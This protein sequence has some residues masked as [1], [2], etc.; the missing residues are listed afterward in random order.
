[1]VYEVWSTI[2]KP[3]DGELE[4]KTNFRLC[5]AIQQSAALK[6]LPL[7]VDAETTLLE[8]SGDVI[9]RLDLRFTSGVAL[10]EYFSFE[11]KRLYAKKGKR[12]YSLVSDYLD[13]GMTRYVKSQYAP[14]RAQGGMIAYVHTGGVDR[15]IA[16]F[17]K[18]L[19]RCFRKL[20]MCPPGEASCSRIRPANTMILETSHQRP[21]SGST[22]L[23][24]HLFLV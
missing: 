8:P 10:E 3:R 23:I 2:Q 6:S 11:C 7:R 20:E 19:K 22:F 13:E 21:A 18:A 24:H 15:A 14:D 17:R 5:A 12:T 4:T 1:M 9:G 16:T